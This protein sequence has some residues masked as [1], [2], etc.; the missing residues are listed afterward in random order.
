MVIIAEMDLVGS[1]TE[2]AVTVTVLP[3]G[4]TGGA[5]YWVGTLLAM[6][7]GLNVPHPPTGTQ[8]KLTLAFIGPLV[9]IAA[10]PAVA[11]VA[12]VVGGGNSLLNDTT[13]A[14]GWYLGSPQA[15]SAT[16]MAVAI[17]VATMGNGKKGWRQVT[18]WLD[19]RR[20]MK[21]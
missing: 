1:F 13:I 15:T 9:T 17:R 14:G 3:C 12:S 11:S 2:V 6:G 20:K 8:L 19:S 10:M 16:N 7:F 4:I 21:F 5:W 18:R